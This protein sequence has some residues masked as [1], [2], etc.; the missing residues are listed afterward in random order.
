MR[1]KDALEGKLTSKELSLLRGFDVIG[2]IAVL[3]IPFEL[4]GRRKLIART[5]KELL[6]Y[7]KVFARK[8]GGHT[9][10][11]RQQP[12]QILLGEKRKTTVHKEH[13]LEFALN[14]ETC[15]FSPRLST[16]RLRIARQVRPGE[17]V[18]VMFSGVAPY[19]LVIARLSKAAGVVGVE[20]NPEAHKYALE[21]VQ[22]NRLGHKVTLIKGDAK[23][24]IPKR[25]FDRVVMP[26]PQRGDEFLGVALKHV[27]KGGVLH[28][29]DFQ[30]EGEFSV[31]KDIV[32]AACKKAK[33]KCKILRV[34]E[35]G[36]VGVRNYRVCVD[37]KVS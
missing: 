31:A 3:E 14:A 22:R 4:E 6:P 27:R 26:W 28:F 9:G 34:V 17:E 19:P 20:A 23:K 18:L 7:I 1:L 12:L 10:V 33:K 8:R 25:L 24:R 21:N 13:G 30:P 37:V 15:Y 35:C 2:D 36:Q 29:Y 11:Y 5:L 16:E 32:L